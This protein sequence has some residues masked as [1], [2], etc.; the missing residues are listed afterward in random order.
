[1][2]VAKRGSFDRGRGG[3]VQNESSLLRRARTKHGDTGTC[4]VCE[5]VDKCVVDMAARNPSTWEQYEGTQNPGSP[6]RSGSVGSGSVRFDETESL[7]GRSVD[8][9]DGQALHVRRRR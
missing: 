2:R 9:Q 7:L 1:V 4:I 6:G 3:Q 8:G 5:V